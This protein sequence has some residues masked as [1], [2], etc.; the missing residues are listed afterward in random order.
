MKEKARVII[1]TGLLLSLSIGNI[2]S[3][4]RVFSNKEN[5]YLQG[6]PKLNLD[7]IISGKFSKDFETYTNGPIY[8]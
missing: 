6:L 1:C 3:P 2:V 8:L 4:K 5:R 7:T